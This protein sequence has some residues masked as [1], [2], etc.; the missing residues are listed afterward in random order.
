MFIFCYSSR[1]KQRVEIFLLH[2]FCRFN[3]ECDKNW[4][5]I[6]KKLILCLDQLTEKIVLL[7]HYL[8]DT[9]PIFVFFW[10]FVC[11]ISLNQQNIAYIR[12]FSLSWSVS[13]FKNSKW[14]QPKVSLTKS[15]GRRSNPMALSVNF[16][17]IQIIY[18]PK[19]SS[20]D[21]QSWLHYCN[22]DSWKG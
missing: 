2:V 5:F 16:I 8:R 18:P 20:C 9:L 22:I 6:K 15:W 3:F 13:I 21:G 19:K 4:K 10:I 7:M 12:N 17:A 11:S 1:D 14:N